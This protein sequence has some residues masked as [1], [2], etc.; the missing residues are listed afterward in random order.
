MKASSPWNARTI[1]L[2]LPLL[3]L[4]V[5]TVACP[6][7]T[8]KASFGITSWT[9]FLILQAIQFAC[10]WS[11]LNLVR[12]FTG[13]T[14][15]GFKDP[16]GTID[17]AGF[18]L[19]TILILVFTADLYRLV[20]GNTAPPLGF[21]L[22][23]TRAANCLFGMVIGFLV[24]SIAWLLGLTTGRLKVEDRV[25]AHFNPAGVVRVLCVGMFFLIL[26]SVVEEGACR[27]F[28]MKLWERYPL[29][30][31]IL[32]PS[33]F[34]A[35]LHL[36]DERFKLLPFYMRFMFGVVQS[37]GY[38]LTNNIWFAVGLHTGINY[39]YF[40]VNGLW[41]AAAVVDLSGRL[42]WLQWVPVIIWTVIAIAGFFALYAHIPYGQIIHP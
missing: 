25:W 14:I 12:L 17:G 15:H 3:T 40:A 31:R 33:F 36:A 24:Q 26:S 30:L 28:P 1:L 32:V 4:I 11:F 9:A 8:V 34:F 39:A 27:A 37:V 35:A 5:L 13:K 16:F 20:V 19:L 23:S 2:I 7:I 22:T 6:F 10:F 18:V 21:A 29:A 38:A 42:G 41:H